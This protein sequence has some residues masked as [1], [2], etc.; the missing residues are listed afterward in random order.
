MKT[1]NYATYWNHEVLNG[2]TGCTFLNSLVIYTTAFILLNIKKKDKIVIITD[3]IE[4][5]SF[6]MLASYVSEVEILIINTEDHEKDITSRIVAFFP[7]AIF[8]ERRD[9]YNKLEKD[10]ENFHSIPSLEFILSTGVVLS[11]SIKFDLYLMKPTIK[12]FNIVE[13]I[14][15]MTFVE[16]L[17]SFIEN[18]SRL[19]DIDMSIKLR[20]RFLSDSSVN[21]QKLIQCWVDNK[22][23]DFT[24]NMILNDPCINGVNL[25]IR[26][27]QYPY[28]VAKLL[29]KQ[30]RILESKADV[31]LF[32]SIS[33]EEFWNDEIAI[34]KENKWL[35]YLC[36]K[37][38]FLYRKYIEIKMRKLMGKF[39]E[40]III[41]PT[42]S[43]TILSLLGKSNLPISTLTIL[44][45]EYDPAF[46]N[47]NKDLAENNGLALRNVEGKG[48]CIEKQI[49]THPTSLLNWVKK[50]CYLRYNKTVITKNKIIGYDTDKLEHSTL[51]FY[52]NIIEEPFI[53]N[54][55]VKDAIYTELGRCIYIEPNYEETDLI[56]MNVFELRIKLWIIVEEIN[57]SLPESLQISKIELID[58][59][60]L[61][62]TKNGKTKKYFYRGPFSKSMLLVPIEKILYFKGEIPETY[63][64]SVL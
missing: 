51:Q 29:I 59:R 36:I 30:I 44:R 10:L 11:N 39:K 45:D 61:I 53:A 17:K 2:L 21:I 16:D 27:Q 43:K 18:E 20:M 15:K 41:N 9:A 31:Y 28:L 3:K 47:C 32:D 50:L 12:Y 58:K 49:I 40:L 54:S 33:F 25:N 60:D 38:P 4:Q 14:N 6:L 37:F 22:H 52:A 7:K 35:N 64:R 19:L 23:V 13:K 8:C 55:L 26:P 24:E 42:F 46:Y 62:K 1:K 57:K 48:V 63:P 34:L 5:M 56:K